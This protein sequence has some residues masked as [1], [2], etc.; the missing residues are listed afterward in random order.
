GGAGGG[1]AV[2]KIEQQVAA[3]RRVRAEVG[4]RRQP[5]GQAAT[6]ERQRQIDRRVPASYVVLHIGV[7]VAVGQV[8]L[9]REGGEQGAALERTKTEEIAEPGQAPAGLP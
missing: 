1:G 4:A 2:V 8:D 7:E 6:P 9:R 3:Q 5:L